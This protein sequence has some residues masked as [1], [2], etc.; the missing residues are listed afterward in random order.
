VRVVP[1]GDGYRLQLAF[2]SLDDALDLAR[3]LGA[4]TPA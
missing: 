2:E 3:R 1:H 4:A